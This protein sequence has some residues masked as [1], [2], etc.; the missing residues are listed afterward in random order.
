MCW[1]KKETLWRDVR[2]KSSSKGLGL[3]IWRELSQMIKEIEFCGERRFLLSGFGGR[4]PRSMCGR[5]LGA[6]WSQMYLKR[7]R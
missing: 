3:N 6:T 2:K 4:S 1:K 5:D 7:G